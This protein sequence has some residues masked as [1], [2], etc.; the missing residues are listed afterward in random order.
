[1]RYT[2][3]FAAGFLA[4]ALSGSAPAQPTGGLRVE[5]KDFS[6]GS[7]DAAGW[8]SFAQRE[9]IKPRCYV[10]T[11]LFRSSPDSL[12]ISGNG[13]PLEYG[14]WTHAIAGITPGKYYRLTAYFTDRSVPDERRQVV[15]RLD[16]RDKS[17]G[18]VAQPDYAYE[19]SAAGEWTRVTLSVPAPPEAASVK[20]ELI[21]GWAPQ[22]TVWWDDISFEET[23]PPPDRWVR[24]GTLSLHPQNNPDN[25]GAF[26]SLLDR[27]AKEKPDIVCMGE[28][29]LNEGHPL[30]YLGTAEPIP[31]PS[32]KRLGEA[33]RKY[34]IYIVAGLL[35]RDGPAAY[36]TAVLIDRQG[37]LAG[38][39]RKVYL[40]REEIEGGLMP[41]SECPV[42]DT[43][44][45]RIGMMICWDAEYTDVAR[46]LAV[47]G[48]EVILVPAAGGFMTLLK[49]RA[50][51]NHLYV[52]SSG[53]TVESSIIDPTGEVLYSTMES[54]VY[55]VIA[56]N[57]AAR[58][59]D[60]W[61]GDMRP[62]FHKEMRPDIVAP[63][64][65]LK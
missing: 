35:E 18:R 23:A 29:I 34:G 59:T 7:Q 55:K 15:A 49:A 41:G 19:T 61:I 38:K 2:P 62:R 45:G 39:Y 9:E 36:N 32:T 25:L 46:A 65:A 17:G 21:L 27:A 52:V 51:E 50:L 5:L 44:F 14:G 3:L 43:D 33:A 57:L 42:F 28:E 13:N 12:A 20:L 31:G 22:G 63:P 47:Q 4:I 24:I 58:F 10:D 54:G 56:V 6:P 53:D 11:G 48:A 16:W 30:N 60:P 64:S 1:M 37:N 40:P 8:S 26:L